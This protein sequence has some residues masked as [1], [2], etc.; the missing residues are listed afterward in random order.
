MRTKTAATTYISQLHP[1]PYFQ[2]STTFKQTLVKSTIGLADQA[3]KVLRN[4]MAYLFAG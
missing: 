2:V 4:L 3:L 1:R